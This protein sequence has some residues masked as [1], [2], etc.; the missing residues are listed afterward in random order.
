M[1]LLVWILIDLQNIRR[2]TIGRSGKNELDSDGFSIA[3]FPWLSGDVPRL[4]LYGFY[5]SQLV[6]H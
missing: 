5:I 1:S 6:I 2:N 3:N 4:P